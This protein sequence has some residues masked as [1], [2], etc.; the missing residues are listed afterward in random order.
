MAIPACLIA[1]P[2]AGDMEITIHSG[3]SFADSETSYNPCPY[4]LAPIDYIATNSLGSSML[5]GTKVAAN[6][7]RSMQVEGSFAVAPNRS[8][9]SQNGYVCI[10]E[11][12]CPAGDL[13]YP[14][15]YYTETNAVSYQYGGSFVYNL[16]TRNVTPF[17]IFGIGGYSTDTN[18]KAHHDFALNIGAGAKFYF[19][20]VGL[21]FEVSDS[22]IPD[23]F[24]TG[25]TEHDLQVQYGFVFRIP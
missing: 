11:L 8:L 23:Y 14:P 19:D 3:W 22:V 20:K 18:E 13:I 21:R 4:C 1:G 7:N 25:K 9:Q 6:L 10:P 24:L 5:F 17:F 15:I 2:E 12:P 16:A